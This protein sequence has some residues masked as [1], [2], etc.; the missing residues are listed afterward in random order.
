[1][2]SIDLLFFKSTRWKYGNQLHNI[3]LH[4]I[5]LIRDYQDEIPRI[6]I[7]IFFAQLKALADT[8]IV[9]V[10]SFRVFIPRTFINVSSRISL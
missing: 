4:K 9:K 2:L 3:I 7:F 8:L 5:C 6:L 1:M 10:F